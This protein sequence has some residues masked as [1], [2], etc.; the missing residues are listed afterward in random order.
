M[1]RTILSVLFA[2]SITILLTY[3]SKPAEEQAAA[4][5]PVAGEEEAGPPKPKPGDRVL[6][7]AG[8][9]TMGSNEKAAAFAPFYA[10]ERKVSLPAYYIDAYEV[11]FGEWI[12]FTTESGHQTESDWRR[13]YTIGKENFP[14]A[15]ITLDDA[16]A[17]AKWAGKRLPTEAEW[18]KAARGPE[19]FKYPWGNQWDPTKS[20][21]HEMARG[22]TVEV[23]SMELD[24]SPYGVHDMMGNVQEWTTDMLKPYPGSP[25]AGNVDFTRGYVV[26]RGGSYAIKGGSMA[27]WT[28]PGYFPKSQFGLGF[29]CVKDA[30]GEKKQ[31]ESPALSV[32]ALN[33]LRFKLN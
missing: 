31:A 17:Y 33:Q 24:R 14:A 28:R 6:I 21:C 22:N 7:P 13:Y 20:N 9:F 8:E 10:P 25:V 5:Q 3:C 32:L 16:K 23:G 12:K 1:K 27:L 15:N 2:L 26:V 19:G 4:E 11:T 29:R 30:E 18:E